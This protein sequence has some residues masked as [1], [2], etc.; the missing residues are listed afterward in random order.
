LVA[1][2]PRLIDGGDASLPCVARLR[3]RTRIALDPFHS[4]RSPTARRRCRSPPPRRSRC[5]QPPG[6]VL[7]APLRRAFR[8]RPS[9]CDECSTASSSQPKRL[10]VLCST[11]AAGGGGA[12]RLLACLGA[13]GD[14]GTGKGSSRCS[15]AAP[16]R[17]LVDGWRAGFP[18]VVNHGQSKHCEAMNKCSRAQAGVFKGRRR[19]NRA[20]DLA[21]GRDPPAPAPKRG[22]R[23]PLPAV[24]RSTR[25]HPCRCPQL[26]DGTRNR[27]RPR[28]KRE[29]D[30][31]AAG[32]YPARGA[33]PE[34]T[35]RLADDAR[36]RPPCPALSE[37]SQASPNR[38]PSEEPREPMCRS[39]A[40]LDLIDPQPRRQ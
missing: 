27:E 25:R 19:S 14:A 29:R 1:P 30:P 7:P 2:H 3:C 4:F 35:R 23:G 17:Y 33:N 32:L 37:A 26:S 13:A 6:V 24:E 18:A 40:D 21:G 11:H 39:H 8:C 36:A 15:A 20:S 28:K 22:R 9:A 16:D 38:G 31:G 34:R 5:R 12:A 10:S